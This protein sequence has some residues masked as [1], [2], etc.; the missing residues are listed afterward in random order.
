[1]KLLNGEI[2]NAVQS[3][4]ELFEKDWPVSVSLSL[5]KLSNKL[6]EPFDAIEKVRVGLVSKYLPIDENG[7]KGSEIKPEDD[8]WGKFSEEF[9]ELMAQDTELVFDVIKLPSKI[10]GKAVVVNP[11]ILVPLEK[12]I[13]IVDGE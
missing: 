2:Y 1:M 11:K 7:N 9:F 12:F 3:L 8:N 10:D 4:N 5:A 13:E 6:S